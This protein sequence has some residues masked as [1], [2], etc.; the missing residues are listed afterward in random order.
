MK[1][2]RWG[3]GFNAVCFML[4]LMTACATSTPAPTDA[5]LIDALTEECLAAVKA[6][7]ID[8]MMTY[9]SED[10]ADYE[11]GDKEDLRVFLK[12][13]KGMGFLDDREIDQSAKVITITGDKAS[14]GPAFLYGAFGS[15]TLSLEG[16]KEEYGWKITTMNFQM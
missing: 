15:A 8:K 4:M 2:V 1:T 5:E 10:F 3:V 16:A 11:I 7:D 6:Q 12:D 14:G 9:V 13:A